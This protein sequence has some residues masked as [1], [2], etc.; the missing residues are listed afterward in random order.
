M[1]IVTSEIQTNVLTNIIGINGKP[2]TGKSTLATSLVESKDV[3]YFDAENGSKFIPGV[4]KFTPTGKAEDNPT[5]WEHFLQASKEVV[6]DKKTNLV[7]D[8]IY[9]VCEWCAK[10]VCEQSEKKE[11][12]DFGFGKGEKAALKELK[13]VFDYFI[14]HNI[15][16]IYISHLKEEYTV[17]K[18]KDS[19]EQTK[20]NSLNLPNWAKNYLVGQSDYIFWLY[21]DGFGE[22]KIKTKGDELTVCKDRPGF[23]PE[24]IPNNPKI[25]K[26]LLF[27]SK[28]K[29]TQR[30]MA[31]RSKM[32]S[33]WDQE[34]DSY[35]KELGIDSYE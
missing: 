20:M 27:T 4:P 19:S 11:L 31:A 14:Q 6:I 5:N 16:I 25:L 21:R 22:L 13:R 3:M 35:L 9:N 7:V 8:N 2:G 1:P 23:L 34:A 32:L 33:H 24:E 18:T 30:V 10:Y 26:A 29:F 28:E 12:S 15:G 17:I